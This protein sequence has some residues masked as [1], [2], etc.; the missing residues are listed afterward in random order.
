MCSL[1]QRVHWLRARAQK[2][3]WEEELVLV[4]H[5][6]DWSTRYFLHWAGLWHDRF[7]DPNVQP[8]PR[9]YAARQSA[10][11]KQ[12]AVVAEHHYCLVNRDYVPLL[13]T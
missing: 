12:L 13:V 3:R 1:V 6:M 7:E 4:K 9:A 10:Q 5:E 11:W 8:G 2:K